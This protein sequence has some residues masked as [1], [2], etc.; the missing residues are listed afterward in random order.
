MLLYNRFVLVCA[1]AT[2]SYRGDE[3]P[4]EHIARYVFY[5]SFFQQSAALTLNDIYQISMCSTVC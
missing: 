2:I 5:T 3:C 4:Q 1:G